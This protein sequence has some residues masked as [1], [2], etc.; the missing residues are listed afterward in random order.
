MKVLVYHGKGFVLQGDTC[1]SSLDYDDLSFDVALYDKKVKHHR[2]V[3]TGK[4]SSASFRRFRS[5]CLLHSVPN[6]DLYGVTLTVPGLHVVSHDEFRN[7][8]HNISR[9]LAKARIPVVWRVELQ[10]RGM[11]HLH[12]V[13]FGSRTCVLSLMAFWFCELDK[14]F[15]YSLEWLSS[16]LIDSLYLSRRWFSGALSSVH[17]LALDGS[18]RAFRYLISHSSK[19]KIEQMGFRG[20]AWG[21]VCRDLF[22]EDSPSLDFDIAPCVY[23][24]VIRRLRR[25]TRSRVNCRYGC[26]AWLCNP[27][28]LL[29]LIDYAEFLYR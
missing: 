19:G 23:W 26:S 20:R 9:K 18:H 8:W 7:L 14:L 15:D 2:G 10:K 6:A 25:L 16:G 5:F 17:V 21:V 4:Y 3:L 1:S 29:R 11:P 24:Y 27:S 28:S 12:C 13:V 22:V